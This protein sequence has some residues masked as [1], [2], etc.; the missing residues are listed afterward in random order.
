MV[1]AIRKR[2]LGLLVP[3]FVRAALLGLL[4]VALTVGALYLLYGVSAG[5]FF[6]WYVLLTPWNFALALI[7]AV[8]GVVALGLV[9]ARLYKESSAEFVVTLVAFLVSGAGVGLWVSSLDAT[10]RPPVQT[11]TGNG[12]AYPVSQN[13]PLEVEARGEGGAFTASVTNLTDKTV[14]VWCYIEAP[15]EGD[16]EGPRGLAGTELRIGPIPPGGTET[17]S[18][19]LQNVEPEFSGGCK[20]TSY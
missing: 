6:R 5:Y 11:L 12:M 14:T 16:N 3:R 10:L 17:A 20:P 15:I 19:S 4:L 8:V 7:L 1:P 2:R 9:F 13:F 18:E